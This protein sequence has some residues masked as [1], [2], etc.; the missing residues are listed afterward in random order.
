MVV[1]LLLFELAPGDLDL[2]GVDDDD[3]VPGVQM[4]GELGLALA[5]DQVGDLGGQ[6]PEDA[7][8]SI[9][10]P[11]FLLDVILFWNKR[12]HELLTLIQR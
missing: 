12:P 7:V 11:P 10:Q 9:D 8:L 2:L 6:T 4:A 1:V 3:E 5:A